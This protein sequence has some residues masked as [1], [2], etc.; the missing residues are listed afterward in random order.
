MEHIAADTMNDLDGVA[1]QIKD[2][3]TG[4]VSSKGRGRAA[5]DSQPVLAALA[6]PRNGKHF[7]YSWDY[8]IP[9][10]WYFDENAVNDLHNQKNMYNRVSQKKH[11][12]LLNKDPQQPK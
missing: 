6:P 3:E 4:A 9:D 7:S 12:F 2:I 8:V 10:H 5:G 1:R 11:I